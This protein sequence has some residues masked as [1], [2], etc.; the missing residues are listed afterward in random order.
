MPKEVIEC[1]LV[2]GSRAAQPEGAADNDG[3]V[4]AGN[5]KIMKGLLEEAGRE[6]FGFCSLLAEREHICGDITAV[7]VEASSEVGDE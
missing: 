5:M 7:Y 6:A 2:L 3:P 1:L 4:S